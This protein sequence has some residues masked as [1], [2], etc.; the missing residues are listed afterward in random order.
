MV[1]IGVMCITHEAEMNFLF[2]LYEG[3]EL[4]GQPCAN[5]YGVLSVFSQSLS[6]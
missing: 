6:N 3:R 2:S 5:I 1:W 4:L